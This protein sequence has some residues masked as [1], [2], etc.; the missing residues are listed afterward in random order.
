MYRVGRAKTLDLP[1]RLWDPIKFLIG[2]QFRI[3]LCIRLDL[4][5]IYLKM[6]EKFRGGEQIPVNM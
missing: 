6:S 3:K 5:E 4:D 2:G 1:E